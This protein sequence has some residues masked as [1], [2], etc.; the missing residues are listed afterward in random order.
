MR[1]KPNYGIDAPHV[2]RNF[3]VFGALFLIVALALPRV[4][5]AH[6]EFLLFPGFVWPAGWFF[7]FGGLMLLYSLVGKYRHRDRILA[8]VQWT[9]TENVLDVGTGRGLLLIGAAKRLTT[10]HATCIDIWNAED[11]SGNGPEGL[12]ANIALEGVGAQTTIKDEDAR[13]M[14]FANGSM[15]VVLSNLCLH[16]IY[17]KPGRAKACSEIARVLKPGGMAVISDYK[18]MK[19]YAGELAKAGLAVEMCPKDW[20]GTF[21]PLRILVARK[22]A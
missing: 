6:V 19:E 17:E 18:L 10:G 9:G 13:A 3:F 2:I 14:S 15:D 8:K 1:E 22:H 21:P 12:K 11:L 20:T 5:I 16:N 4:T 7:L